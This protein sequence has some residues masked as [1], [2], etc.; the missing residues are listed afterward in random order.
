MATISSESNLHS[1]P[2][3]KL[4]TDESQNGVEKLTKNGCN[5][6]DEKASLSF[7]SEKPCSGAYNEKSIDDEYFDSYADT[8][9]HRT[10][11]EDHVRTD[12]YHKAIMQ[13][14]S[15]IKDKV[16]CDVGC[17][18]GILSMFC[19]QAGAKKVYAIDASKIATQAK[20]VIESNGFENIITVF[21]GRA[22]DI[23]LPEKVDVVVSEW[24]GY[25]LL[26]ETMLPSVLHVRD[27]WL[28]PGGHMF[29]ERATLHIALGE[30]SWITQYEESTYDFWVALHPMYG[31]EMTALADHAVARYLEYA[32]V[33]MLPQKDVLS[34]PSTVCDL[35]LNKIT[36][37]E[38]EV[39][40]SSFS[41]SSMGS[42]NLN[43]IVCWFDVT[44][45]GGV[46]IST[47]PDLEDTHWQNTVLPLPDMKVVQDST[48]VGVLTISQ[49]NKRSLDI[50]LQYKLSTSENMLHR[51]Y[52][53]DENCAELE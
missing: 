40:S 6:K 47:S 18:S 35:D 43:C 45:P 1:P 53:L 33:F 44:F 31:L 9:V 10:M 38:L 39:I 46:K 25:M 3:K 8:E 11:I 37:K 51:R 20:K 50:K 52:R 28:K 22:E 29:P 2:A 48:V 42:R 13:D 49:H 30:A 15:F 14:P 34:L 4:K 32:H 19:A 24:M 36:T 12:A 23:E 7:I 41:L 16:I 5:L 27:K 17:G 26:Y 21:E